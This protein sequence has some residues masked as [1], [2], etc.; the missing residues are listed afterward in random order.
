MVKEPF[1]PLIEQIVAMLK[2]AEANASKS[3][4]GTVDPAF[5]KKLENLRVAVDQFRKI[6]NLQVLAHGLSPEEAVR[7]FR[8]N[9]EQYSPHER[10]LM[11]A[12]IRLGL[13]AVVLR[14]GLAQARAGK[15]KSFNQR[16]I[17]KNTQES[18]RK[19]RRKFKNMKGDSGWRKL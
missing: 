1:Q 10:K 12:L 3:L 5:V 16:E 6:C 14:A 11:Q 9:P 18:I 4:E 8:E 15:S 17:G 2:F 19:R 13:N 7:K